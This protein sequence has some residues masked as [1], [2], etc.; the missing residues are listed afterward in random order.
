MQMQFPRNVMAHFR[1]TIAVFAALTLMLIAAHAADPKT[2]ASKENLDK[3]VAKLLALR[4]DLPIES[5]YPA[6][7]EGLYGCLL[8]TSPSP[9]DAS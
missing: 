1:A 8:Y 9:R 6:A 5:V 3:A 4:P 2:S 7:V